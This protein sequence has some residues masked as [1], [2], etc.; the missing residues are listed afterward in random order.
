MLGETADDD[1]RQ[2]QLSLAI[3][4]TWED[5]RSGQV[6][7]QRQISIAPD[8]VPLV[9]RAG[10]APEVGQSLATAN[11]QVVNDLAQQIVDMMEMPW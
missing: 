11:Q 5:L 6:L 10:F 1:P 8:M 4:V 3:E 7:Q 2:L 9:G